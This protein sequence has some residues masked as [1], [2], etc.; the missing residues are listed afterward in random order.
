MKKNKK[1]IILFS[2]FILFIIITAYSIMQTYA[3]YY[4]QLNTNFS[5]DIKKW[6][7]K[8]NDEDILS[9]NELNEIVQLQFVNDENINNGK[10]VPGAIAY[11]DIILD[12]SYVDLDFRMQMDMEQINTNKNNDI[13]VIGYQ[14]SDDIESSSEEITKKLDI[15]E[16]DTIVLE[17]TDLINKEES[18]KKRILIFFKWNDDS[19]NI[20]ND[21]DDTKY[22]VVEKNNDGNQVIKYNVK[23]MFTQI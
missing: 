19:N 16:T 13:K 5:L 14:I 21:E 9:H 1:V 12:C 10:M 17:S 11:F 3:K 22:E 7:I 4:E 20:M 6:L 23:L 2:I 15:I 8:I 18:N